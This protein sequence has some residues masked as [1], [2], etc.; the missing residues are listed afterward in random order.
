MRRA[1]LCLALSMALGCAPSRR[2]PA[3][4]ALQQ[5][6]MRAAFDLECP[7]Q[8]ISLYHFDARAKGV[9]GCGRRLTYV[10]ICEPGVGS[11]TW[12]ID[13]PRVSAVERPS[14]PLERSSAPAPIPI[15]I[16]VVQ[17]ECAPE[18]PMSLAPEPTKP[19]VY[20]TELFPEKKKPRAPEVPDL[21]F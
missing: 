9:F 17:G 3:R 1:V 7:A 15:R 20:R 5:L 10:E 12:T 18:V 11:C 16:E 2:P 19:R 8:W 4:A 13:A 14:P 6:Q 21:G